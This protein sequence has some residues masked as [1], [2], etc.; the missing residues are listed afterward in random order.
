MTLLS[1]LDGT[2]KS[3]SSLVC[4]FYFGGTPA[5]EESASLNDRLMNAD[6]FED[7]S[8]EASF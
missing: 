2:N 3:G 1:V 7:A 5:E 8:R 4:G 6:V